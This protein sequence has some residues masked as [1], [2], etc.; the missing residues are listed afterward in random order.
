MTKKV[1]LRVCGETV[2]VSFGEDSNEVLE[3]LR[4][5]DLRAAARSALI[6]LISSYGQSQNEAALVRFEIA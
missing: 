2:I 4:G 1:A 6:D 5:S 3:G